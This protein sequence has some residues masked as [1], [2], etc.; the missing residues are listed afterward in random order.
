MRG[1]GAEGAPRGAGGGAGS[2]ALEQG[3]SVEGRWGGAWGGAAATRG[4]P[5]G[6]KETG[7]PRRRGAVGG[8]ACLGKGAGDGTPGAP[9]PVLAGGTAPLAAGS[10]RRLPG[11]VR[12]ALRG[13]FSGLGLFLFA[14]LHAT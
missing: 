2:A 11:H 3:P 14:A 10:V 4:A 9:G 1:S 8:A 5:A 12:K 6:G 7:N 13:S